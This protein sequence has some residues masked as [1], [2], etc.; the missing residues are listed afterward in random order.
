MNTITG[1]EPTLVLENSELAGDTALPAGPNARKP[2]VWTAFVTW[3]VAAIVGELA[4]FAAYIAV[5]FTI[6][7]IM[8]LHGAHPATVQARI[9]EIFQEP[10]PVLLLSLVPFQLG[11]LA[12]VLFAA[13]LSKEP[14]KQRLGLV[15]QAGSVFGGFKLASMAAFTISAA[16]ATL[17]VTGLFLGPPPPDTQIDAAMTDGSWW[18]VTTLTI[19]LSVIPALVEETLFRGYMLRRLLK[20]WSPAVAIGVTS[21]LFAIL[22][23]DS[24][25]HIIAVVPF[26]LVV[27]LLAYRTNS[28]KPG[29]LVHAIHNA[30]IFGFGAVATALTP[31]VGAETIGLVALGMVG[32]LGV[33]G[34]PAVISLLRSPKPAPAVEA[35]VAPE[36]VA[37]SL[38]S[39]SR[40]LK[41]PISLI[42]SRLTGP[43]M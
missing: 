41:L 26:A 38:V 1:F 11:L 3:L 16:L 18:V 21:V 9:Q 5:G 2:R 43:A 12:V 42:D 40:E 23:M 30:A 8:G 17:F 13:W 33:I 25:Q 28:T 27:G 32:L 29:M 7:F 10:V 20:R 39:P 6:G 36:P 15:P 19:L 24:V 34:L 31:Y 37:E 35:Q 4:V 14:I 22:H